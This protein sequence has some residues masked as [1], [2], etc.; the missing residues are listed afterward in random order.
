MRLGAVLKPREVIAQGGGLVLL[1]LVPCQDALARGVHVLD[2]QVVQHH[3]VLGLLDDV[4][5]H[6]PARHEPED[7]SCDSLYDSFVTAY[8]KICTSSFCPIL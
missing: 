6:A 4:L 2:D 7:D 1:G 8:L 3:L 5:V